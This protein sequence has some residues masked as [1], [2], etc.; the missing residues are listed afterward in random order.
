MVPR[1]ETPAPNIEK[2]FSLQAR[3][4][5]RGV[6]FCLSHVEL[7][8]LG[9][10]SETTS[11]GYAT[12]RKPTHRH[13]DTGGRTGERDGRT[14]PREPLAQPVKSFLPLSGRL[15]DPAGHMTDPS[16]LLAGTLLSPL[17]APRQPVAPNGRST[18]ASHPLQGHASGLPALAVPAS[19][20]GPGEPVSVRAREAPD[21]RL[22]PPSAPVG[23]AAPVRARFDES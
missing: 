9:M 14:S 20:A 6:G 19:A 5:T 15:R 1:T 3:G 22:S 11:P 21:T 7:Q 17:S 23:H 8:P 13:T 18:E 4:R 12:S 10:V 16:F 2:C